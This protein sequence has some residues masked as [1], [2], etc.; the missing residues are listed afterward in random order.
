ME[1]GQEC[2]TASDLHATNAHLFFPPQLRL[3]CMVEMDRG[4]HLK[5]TTILY[6]KELGIPC[7]LS[8]LFQLSA[9]YL[10]EEDTLLNV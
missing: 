6:G 10:Q 1:K 2:H 8:A 9:H 3:L 5:P 4:S 7:V